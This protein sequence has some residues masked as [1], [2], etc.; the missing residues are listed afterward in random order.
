MMLRKTSVLTVILLVGILSSCQSSTSQS[1]LSISYPSYYNSKFDFTAIFGSKRKLAEYQI[2]RNYRTVESSAFAG[3]ILNPANYLEDLEADVFYRPEESETSEEPIDYTDEVLEFIDF[4]TTLGD[5]V[6]ALAPGPLSQDDTDQLLGMLNANDDVINQYDET[7]LETILYHDF[8]DGY[9]YAYNNSHK[10]ENKTY[11]RYAD[12]ILNADGQGII[13]YQDG[14]DFSYTLTEQI[15]ATGFK[16]YDM[17]DETFP[18]GSTK[19]EDYRRTS[20]RVS[21]NLKLAIQTGGGSRTQRFIA[22]R[23]EELQ[24]F[25]DPLSPTYSTNYSYSITAE[26]FEDNLV[27]TYQ[28]H[29]DEHFDRNSELIYEMDIVYD[30]TIEGGVVTN[31][32][33]AQVY[34][35]NL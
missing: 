6:D 3:T 26:K 15:W 35:K 2:E 10:I 1:T 4:Q 13:Y 23:L 29:I 9:Y 22:N 17:R 24:P 28:S 34:W 8:F 16:I 7:Y 25:I 30:A 32:T 12:N 21:G 31:A 19:A 27:L 11:T 20:D 18:A 5:F 33:M 14:F